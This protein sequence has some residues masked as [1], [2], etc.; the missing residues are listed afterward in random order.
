MNYRSSFETAAYRFAARSRTPLTHAARAL[1]ALSA[2]EA[3]RA[4]LAGDSRISSRSVS[5]LSKGGLPLGRL[6]VGF[7][8]LIMPVQII[9]DKP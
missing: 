5:P 1:P 7:M 8:A 2:A 9:L 3:Y 6:E 4:F